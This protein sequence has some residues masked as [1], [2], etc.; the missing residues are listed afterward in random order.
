MSG[1]TPV[2]TD[3]H[4]TSST[5]VLGVMAGLGLLLGAW[6]LALALPA[7]G[8]LPLAGAIAHVCGMLAGYGVLVL[9]TFMSRWPILEHG[10]G[11]DRL[12]RWHAVGG[13]TVL[14]LVILHAGAAVLAWAESRGRACRWPSGTC[15]G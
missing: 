3:D 7:P 11:A 6:P 8:P 9:M 2:T 5:V 1:T 4:R 14:T 12:A 15:S 13:R 10:I